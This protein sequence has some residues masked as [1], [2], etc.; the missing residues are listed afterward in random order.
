VRILVT[1]G[2]GVLGRALL[3]GLTAAGHEVIAPSRTDLDLYDPVAVRTALAGVQAVYHLATR[4]PGPEAR[5]LPG[6]WDENDRLRSEATRLL[7]DAALVADVPA[8]LLPSV[9]FVYPA[10]GTVDED[11][12]V[13]PAANLGSMVEAEAQCRRFA[14]AG[15]QGVILRLGLLWGPGAESGTPLDRYGAALHVEDAGSALAAAL[16]AP[17]G[18]YNVVSD[19]GRVSNARFKAATGWRPAR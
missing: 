16:T 2:S 11:T 6:A 3:P 19:G 15:Y 18:V 8:F 10:E 14:E 17:A 13:T 4:I 5:S 9:A 1:G 12:P 7:V